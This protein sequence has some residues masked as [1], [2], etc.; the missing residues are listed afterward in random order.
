M[1]QLRFTSP[2]SIVSKKTRDT[3]TRVHVVTGFL[4]AGKTSL[5]KDIARQN[6]S[7]KTT[8]LVS[9][10]GPFGVDQIILD[11]TSPRLIANCICCSG[12]DECLA[13]LEELSRQF[14]LSV[15]IDH[16]FV[17]TSGLSNTIELLIE[18][19][20]D[21]RFARN[22]EIGRVVAVVDVTRASE[23]FASYSEWSQ[24]IQSA[25]LIVLCWEDAVRHH[26]RSAVRGEVMR[27]LEQIDDTRRPVVAR[28]D[29]L[30]Q[31]D[32]FLQ[33]S[34]PN[35]ELDLALAPSG[36]NAHEKLRY[37]GF[38]VT[39][40]YSFESCYGLA[41]ALLCLR[42]G[43]KRFKAVLPAKEATQG[44]YLM[45]IVSG[46][47]QRIELLQG[48]QDHGTIFVV[49]EQVGESEVRGLVAMFLN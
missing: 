4:G 14:A 25:D 10:A 40:K 18:L 39:G 29:F 9:E 19:S 21:I 5:L 41:K 28:A 7:K 33:G 26:E 6:P 24:Q 1:G 38:N 43:L 35:K 2:H 42:P 45:Q 3:R 16:V 12:Y 48:S 22:F 34:T 44:A 31:L 13:A 23:H 46:S 32:N 8:I 30:D 47:I 36:E 11:D 27:I 20:A 37:V 15:P 17:E 49:D